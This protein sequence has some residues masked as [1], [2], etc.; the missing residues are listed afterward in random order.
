[1]KSVRLLNGLVNI[2][3]EKPESGT[4]PGDWNKACIVMDRYN[5]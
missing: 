2:I 5:A 1:M 4:V 3:L